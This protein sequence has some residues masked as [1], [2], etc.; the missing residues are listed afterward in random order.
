MAWK[1]AGACVTF[2]AI[3]ARE[4]LAHR[5]D[6]LPLTGLRLQRPR[7]VLAE[8]AQPVA[9][10]ARARRRRRDH[11]TFAGK[12]VGER[13]AVGTLARKSA[14]VCRLGDG[15]FR[16]QFH[17]LWR[18]LPALRTSAPID[19]PSA[20]SAPTVVRNLALQLGDPQLLPRDQR[21]VL[22]RFGPGDGQFRSHLKGVRALD[23]QPPLS[24][25]RY[26]REERRERDPCD[27]VNHKFGDLWRPK[28]RPTPSF[29]HA[30]PALFG[31][32]VSCGFRQSIP[33][34]I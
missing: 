31:L 28:M 34:S 16:R 2:L 24:G 6:H 15:L 12:M 11:H 7:H 20:P 4:L 10:A 23:E 29:F 17:P 21:Q 14:H 30:H 19:R 18:W 25:R 26:R 9:A 13:I 33:S 3:A 1:G 32:H 5:L 22:G 27:A 8:L